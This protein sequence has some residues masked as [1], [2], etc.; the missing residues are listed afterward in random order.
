MGRTL[1]FSLSG[2]GA[3]TSSVQAVVTITANGVILDSTITT[4]STAEWN[5]W[6]S[7]FALDVPQ[8]LTGARSSAAVAWTTPTGVKSWS[9]PAIP[10]TPTRSSRSGNWMQPGGPSL[11][12]FVL[13]LELELRPRPHVTGGDFH[14]SGRPWEGGLVTVRCAA[15]GWSLIIPDPVA[16]AA[17]AGGRPLGLK[18]STGA[19]GN[20]HEPY[21]QVP[22]AA[23]IFNVATQPVQGNLSVYVP[24]LRGSESPAAC[25][26]GYGAAGI[27]SH[28]VASVLATGSRLF[29]VVSRADLEF[30]IGAGPVRPLELCRCGPRTERG[31][32]RSLACRPRRPVRGCTQNAPPDHDAF[33]DAADRNP[34][35]TVGLVS[36]HRR[37]PGAALHGGARLRQRADRAAGQP[38]DSAGRTR[39]PHGFHLRSR[40]GAGPVPSVAAS[41]PQ[42]VRLVHRLHGDR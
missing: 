14:R 7:G 16:L 12:L 26:N 31:Q 11:G 6:D 35:R 34:P 20:L 36:P 4:N 25:R 19:V 15:G 9:L 17:E 29:F 30:R 1:T 37:E 23:T 38:R 39:G 3:A 28:R 22:L 5:M 27:I 32:T 24:E 18:V 42:H 10:H 41:R 8:P 2:P 33:R 13:R 40:S 21:R